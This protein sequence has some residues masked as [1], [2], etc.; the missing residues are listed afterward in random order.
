MGKDNDAQ[1]KGTPAAA[2]RKLLMAMGVL[3]FQTALWVFFI[4]L[5]CF[6]FVFY[7]AL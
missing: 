2:L 4:V 1:T 3:A 7:K 5:F 6:C